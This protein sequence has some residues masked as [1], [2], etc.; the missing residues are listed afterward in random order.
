MEDMEDVKNICSRNTF[1]DSE[2]CRNFVSKA[3][4]TDIMVKLMVS[5]LKSSGCEVNINRHIACEECSDNVSGGYDPVMHQVIICQNNC[6]NYATVQRTLLHELVHMFDDCR[7]N[8]DFRNLDHLACTEVRA[9]NLAHCSFMDALIKGTIPLFRISKRHA[10]CVKVTA[11]KS[12]MIIKNVS[13][14]EANLAINK[15]FDKCYNDL[16]PLGRRTQGNSKAAQFA[17]QSRYRYGLIE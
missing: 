8:V 9:A 15:V 16:A 17:Y 2:E 4:K 13:K 7:A 14:E 10:E 3:F 5:A 11:A 1:S 6:K 12:V